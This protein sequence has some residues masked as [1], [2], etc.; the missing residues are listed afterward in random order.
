MNTWADS[1]TSRSKSNA[2]SD[3]VLIW[4]LTRERCALARRLRTKTTESFDESNVG[5]GATQ[6]I[7]RPP[8]HFYSLR[9]RECATS[10]HKLRPRSS[11]DAYI[12]SL[13]D[14]T[15]TFFANDDK[16]SQKTR[17]SRPPRLR[18]TSACALSA[19]GRARIQPFYRVFAFFA[20][21][22]IKLISV[23]RVRRRRADARQYIY[24]VARSGASFPTRCERKKLSID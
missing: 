19:F 9:W 11:T 3:Y 23:S 21:R 7:F 12:V 24:V 4:R 22:K 2:T 6:N 15:L 16:Y 5:S 13:A 20:L 18:P 1:G 17:F 14:P 8:I 10:S